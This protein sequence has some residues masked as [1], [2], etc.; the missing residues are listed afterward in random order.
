MR[1]E[2]YPSSSPAV[3]AAMTPEPWSCS[4]GRYAR[5]GMTSDSETSTGG[6][7]R[8]A[9]TQPQTVATTTPT[10][11]PMPTTH[12]KSPTAWPSTNVPLVTAATET[13]KAVSAV[14]S[15]M[16]LSPS[17]MATSRW[18]TASGRSTATAEIASGGATIAPRAKAA[19]SGMP[20][21]IALPTNA[22]TAVVNTTRPI[23]SNRIGR[24]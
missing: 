3:T 9:Q 23:E 6:S 18:G 15:L 4:A 8:R 11:T 13:P 14:A 24:R 21:M 12:T 10:T 16:R 2:W 5:Y 17:R 7:N 19:A 1:D 20:G 22:T